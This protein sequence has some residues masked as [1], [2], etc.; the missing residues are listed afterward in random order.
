M[1]YLKLLL[2]ILSLCLQ[3][4]LSAKLATPKK[5]FSR[6]ATESSKSINSNGDGILLISNFRRYSVF[7]TNSTS[8]FAKGLHTDRLN[9][10]FETI[11]SGIIYHLFLSDG[12]MNNY[13][14]I[15]LLGNRNIYPNSCGLNFIK[16]H[17]NCNVLI[18]KT[19]LLLNCCTSTA[20]NINSRLILIW[21]S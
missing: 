13:N 17:L 6:H 1:N 11:W 10:N 4:S 7:N 12:F 14:R 16:L 20:G 21:K 18:A 8:S 19:A 15:I 2:F 5:I 9:I 3:S